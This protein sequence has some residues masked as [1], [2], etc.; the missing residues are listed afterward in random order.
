MKD[1]KIIQEETSQINKNLPECVSFE[2]ARPKLND[3][4]KAI[5]EFIKIKLEKKE[6]IRRADVTD[7]YVR[8]L[9][10]NLTKKNLFEEKTYCRWTEK[11]TYRSWTFEQQKERFAIKNKA[12]MWFKN[13]L[14]TVILKGRLIVL[15]IIEIE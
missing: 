2:N 7:L 3:S 12:L 5:L 9:F 10:P 6:P 4:N 15:P 14:A 8:T 13:N 1:S 11:T